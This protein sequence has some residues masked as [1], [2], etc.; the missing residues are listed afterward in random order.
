MKLKTI[1]KMSRETNN[2]A[3][4]AHTE[5]TK[6]GKVIAVGCP[7]DHLYYCDKD[8]LDSSVTL[9][10]TATYEDEPTLFVHIERY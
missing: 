1:L 8:L 3:I 10:N 7:K 2:I 4:V 6:S 9:L 5:I